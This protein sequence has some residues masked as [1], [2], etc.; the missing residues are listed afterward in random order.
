MKHRIDAYFYTLS[1]RNQEEAKQIC[2]GNLDTELILL[3]GGFKFNQSDAEVKQRIHIILRQIRMVEANLCQRAVWNKQSTKTILI[4]GT[5]YVYMNQD[6]LRNYI[7]I[8][9][10]DVTKLRR[11]VS[12]V[13]LVHFTNTDTD[14]YK[15]LYCDFEKLYE[16]FEKF[17]Q[18]FIEFE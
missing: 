8:E 16:S 15:V 2:L 5:N 10:D 11:I 1:D 6:Y 17:P 7:R 9:S 13:D 12:Y 14:L 3:K 4:G 18:S